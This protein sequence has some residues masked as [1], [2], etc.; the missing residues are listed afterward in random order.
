MNWFVAEAAAVAR[1]CK[2]AKRS[3]RFWVTLI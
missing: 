3:R 2:D 1:A